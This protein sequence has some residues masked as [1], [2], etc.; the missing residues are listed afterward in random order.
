M[1]LELHEDHLTHRPRKAEPLPN[2]RCKVGDWLM[3]SNRHKHRTPAYMKARRRFL[4]RLQVLAKQ[5]LSHREMAEILCREGIRT[6]TG[7]L[8]NHMNVREWYVRMMYPH[9]GRK[10]EKL[11]RA[12][13]KKASK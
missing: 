2:R 1:G 8:P 7:A 5:T 6:P 3:W 13:L 12:K 9:Q 4:R 11:L 10:R